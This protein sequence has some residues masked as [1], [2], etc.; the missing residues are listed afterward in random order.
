MTFVTAEVFIL[1]FSVILIAP[2]GEKKNDKEV[3]TTQTIDVSEEEK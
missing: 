3:T 1:F 2:S